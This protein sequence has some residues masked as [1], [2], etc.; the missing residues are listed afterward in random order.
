MSVSLL[1][2]W[3]R[4]EH[5][6][7]RRSRRI[8]TLRCAHGAGLLAIAIVSLFG[9]VRCSE[10]ASS[11]GAA[12]PQDAGA[13][14]AA[15]VALHDGGGGGGSAGS[16]GAAHDSAAHDVNSGEP[17]SNPCS[18]VTCSGHGTCAP[19][20]GGQAACTCEK[21]YQASGLNCVS[22]QLCAAVQCGRCQECAIVNGVATCTCL[23]GFKPNG[24]DSCTPD[25]NP[26]DTANCVPGQE[27]CVTEVHC[28]PSG[29]CVPTCDCSNCAN[30]GPGSAWGTQCQ[31]ADGGPLA[32]NKPC[33]NGD[34]CLPY[35]PGMCWPGEGCYSQ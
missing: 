15:D 28:V 17:L 12:A 1:Q 32:C 18:G 11:N 20:D 4:R 29:M 22:N 30:C 24:A 21:G 10:D 5:H 6:D 13:E 27:Q 16:D 33:P 19:G 35:S 23:A 2:A 25:P 7:M 34:T 31:D 26:C 14:A 9:L 3:R 8:A